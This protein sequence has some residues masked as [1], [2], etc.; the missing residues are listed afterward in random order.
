MKRIRAILILFSILISWAGNVE[1]QNRTITGTVKDSQGEPLVGASVVAK[2]STAGTYTD[3]NGAFTISVPANTTALVVR[4]LGFRTREVPLTASGQI[5]I[6]LESDVLGL[7]EIVV[8]A[9]GIPV[10]KKKLAYSVQDVSSEQLTAANNPNTLTALSGKVAGLQVISSSGSPGSSVYLE[11]RGASS[12]TGNNQPLFVVDG[13]P[14]DNSYNYSGSPDNVGVL[15]NNNLLESVNNSNRAIDLNPEEIASITVLKGPA[16]TALYGIRAANGAIIITTKKGTAVTGKGLR[17][18]FTSALTWEEVN[19][20]PKLQNKY[21]KGTGGIASSYESPQAGSWGAKGDTLYWDP[22]QPTPFNQ[23][24]QLIGQTKALQI[25]NDGDPNTL[26]P[27]PFKPY[28]NVGKFFQTGNSFEN[29]LSLSGGGALGGF[30]LALGSLTQEGVVPLS[31]F[32]RYN[33]RL[34]GEM[35]ISPQWS[36]AGSVTYVK[37]GGKR[38]Q[39]GSNLSGLMLDL[40]RTPPSF[41][42]SNGSDDP[43]DPSAYMLPNG[44]QRNYRGGVGYDNPYW[45]INMNPFTDDVNRMYGFAEISFTPWSWLRLTERLGNDFYSDRRRQQF[46]INS[47]SYPDGQVFTQ[48]YFYR[49]VNND[50]LA[51]AT[52]EINDKVSVSLTLGNNIYSQYQE[53]VYVQGDN[54]ILPDFYHISNATNVLS[55]NL[56]ERYRT[57]AFYGVLDVAIADQLYVNATGRH[58]TSSTLPVGN[59][60][61]FYPSISASWV[62]TEALGLSQN[63]SFSYGKLRAS[64]AQVGKDAPPYVLSQVYSSAV[65]ADGWTSGFAFPIPNPK[66]VLTSGYGHSST[67]G[68]TNLKPERVSAWEIGADLRFINNRIG[69]DLTYY[70]SLSQDQIIPA[71][72]A[73][74]TGY[75]QTF[76]NSGKMENRGV[77]LALNLTPVKTRDWDW[78]VGLNWSHNKSEV[79]ALAN[80]VDVLYLGGFEGAAIFAVVGEQYGSIYGTRWLRDPASGQIIIDDGTLGQEGYPV[81]DAQVGVVGDINPD[82]IAGISTNIRYKNFS[83]YALLDIREGGDIWNG[84]Y[85]AL[86]NFGC[87]FETGEKREDTVVFEGLRGH[88]DENGNLVIEGPNNQEVLTDESWYRFGNGS[89]FIGPIEQFVEDGS[90]VKLREVA[91]TVTLKPE[92]LEKTPLASMDVSFIGRNLWLSTKYRG[93]DPETSLTGANNSQGMDYFNMPGTRSFGISLR[94][95]L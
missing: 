62:F 87:T 30:R 10:E 73:G 66:G 40:L 49:H 78:D 24:G 82:W 70:R 74:S 32:R 41:D 95:T 9:I 20:L 35:R 59:N 90:Y 16:A 80:G 3:E 17:A 38:V 75:T 22:N 93:V 57:Y 71:P 85:G 23:Y 4:Y 15:I 50:L 76:L 46:A 34:A 94:L 77:E 43:T 18:T 60:S 54:L 65:V 68:N 56:I 84:T 55:R 25:L 58:E 31:D 81:M 36:I 64:Y 86:N 89:G 1:A 29:N 92:W 44:Q 33:A 67:L 19:K 52:R 91:F 72:I 5:D 83:L 47:R 51:T 61:F 28:D 21:V 12:I 42:N 79:I 13:V 14:L 88:V 6:I 48:D 7:D 11:L 26:D 63:Q 37:S 8:T 27:I 39:Q 45:T 53:Q 2:G 69:L